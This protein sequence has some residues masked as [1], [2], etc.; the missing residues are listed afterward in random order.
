MV[1]LNVPFAEKDQAREMGARWEPSIKKWYVPDGVVATP[2]EAWMPQFPITPV[3]MSAGAVRTR[4]KKARV[5]VAAAK[6][7]A[8]P[9]H[10]AANTRTGSGRLPW[11]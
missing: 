9:S 8:A 3:S 2:F 7:I 6:V 11:E 5:Q 4:A 1:I 10:V